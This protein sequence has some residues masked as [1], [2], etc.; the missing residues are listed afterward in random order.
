VSFRGQNHVKYVNLSLLHDRLGHR[1]IRTLFAADEHNVW[2]DTK[3]RI[4]PETDCVSCQIAMIWTTNRNKLPH[5]PASHPGATLFMDILHCKSSPGLTSKTSHAY[6]LLLVDAYLRFSSIYGLPN[7]SSDSVVQAIKEYSATFCMADAYGYI[8]ID[9]IEAD[10]GSEFT[11]EEFKQFCVSQRINISLAAPKHQENNHLA[12]RSWQTIHRMAHS[13]LVHAR[14]PDKY[15]FHAIRYAATI[16]NVL[17]VKNLFNVD[18]DICSPFELFTGTKP[19]VSHLRVFGC[20]AVAKRSV[21][22]VEGLS[23]QLC[24]EK[25]IRGIFIGLPSNQKGYLIFLPSSR[26]IACSGDVSFDETFYSTVV[27]T[28]RRFEEGIALKPAS[29]VIPGPDMDLEETGD[30]SNLHDMVEELPEPR[31]DLPVAPQI[32]DDGQPVHSRPQ[33]TRRAPRRLSFD[34]NQPNC[35]WNELA[36]ICTDTALVNDCA[37]EATVQLDAPGADASIFEP[38]PANL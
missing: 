33:R 29:H 17:P 11:S 25:G 36:H 20:P 31:G 35:D 3:I 38:A 32:V 26:M 23:T 24:T 14:L 18:G 8:D 9:R 15:H 34:I 2:H 4:E 5:T 37:A 6:C 22:S 10:A 12:E 27:T 19:L 21:I 28:W 1:A 13:M 30:V 7:K 16:F